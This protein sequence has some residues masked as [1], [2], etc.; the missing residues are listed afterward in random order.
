MYNCAAR[1]ISLS[2]KTVSA[3]LHKS[4]SWLPIKCRITYKVLLFT[5]T[6]LQSSAPPDISALISRYAAAHIL[7]ST[8]NCFLSIPFHR[9]PLSRFKPF[10]LTAPYPWNSITLSIH[11]VPSL[12]TF[13]TNLTIHLLN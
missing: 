5:F 1:I 6:A 4:F 13:K 12:P 2:P 11:K 9:Y 10:S 7:R 8:Q 3:H